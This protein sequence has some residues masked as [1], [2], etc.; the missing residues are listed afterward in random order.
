MLTIKTATL[1]VALAAAALCG[2]VATQVVARV[3]AAPTP[4]CEFRASEFDKQFREG[5]YKPA[6][7]KEF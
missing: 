1:V 6:P 7:P 4:Q 2:G 3:V 5:K